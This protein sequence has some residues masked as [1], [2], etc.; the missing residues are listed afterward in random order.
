MNSVAKAP[1][2]TEKKIQ[3]YLSIEKY[4][5]CDMRQA[6]LK[7]VGDRQRIQAYIKERPY[8]LLLFTAIALALVLGFLPV[9]HI[10]FQDKTMFRVPLAIIVFIIPLF[11]VFFWL[12]YLLTKRFLYSMT[13][14][15]TH[16]LITVSTAI[17]VVIILYIVVTPLQ[18]T[19][20]GYFNTSL[21]DRPEL[22]GNATRI[23]FII[24]VCGQCIYLAN[25]LLG[26]FTKEK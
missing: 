17:L 25:L 12:L 13:I 11:L 18:S 1:T 5:F 16:V 2:T 10:D 26:L 14:T 24:F 4:N 9:A 21:I 3:L 6:R 15:W 20:H 8:R 7:R 19:P 23:V 22:I